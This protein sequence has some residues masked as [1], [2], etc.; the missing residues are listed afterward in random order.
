MRRFEVL[1]LPQNDLCV[2]V[3]DAQLDDCARRAESTVIDGPYPSTEMPDGVRE[4]VTLRVNDAGD[5][6]WLVRTTPERR[7]IIRKP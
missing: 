7:G 2:V 1:E 5:V 4:A 3:M 6:E